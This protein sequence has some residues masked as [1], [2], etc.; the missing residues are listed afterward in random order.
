[1]SADTAASEQYQQ[2]FFVVEDRVVVREALVVAHV[3]EGFEHRD[4]G[5]QDA[6]GHGRL[7]MSAIS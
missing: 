6:L 2:A 4:T 1:M 3:I 7:K 5:L